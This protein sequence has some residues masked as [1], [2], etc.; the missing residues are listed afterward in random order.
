[1]FMIE[2]FENFSMLVVTLFFMR[3]RYIEINVCLAC[4][5]S[6]FLL[7]LI[8]IVNVCMYVFAQFFRHVI[9]RDNNHSIQY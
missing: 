6:V 3:F 4:F 8:Y 5:H 2:E 9:S 7:R 1:M